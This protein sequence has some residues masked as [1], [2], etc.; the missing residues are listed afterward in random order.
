MGIGLK[1]TKEY[2]LIIILYVICSLMLREG[3]K[4][5]V[6]EIKLLRRIFGLNSKEVTA[7]WRKLHNEELHNMHSSPN[8]VK[9]IELKRVKWVYHVECTGEKYTTMKT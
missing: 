2:N 9:T 5:R 7:G 6:F 3:C 8:T 1:Y 4:F